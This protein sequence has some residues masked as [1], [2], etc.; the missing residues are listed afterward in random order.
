MKT[1]CLWVMSAISNPIALCGYKRGPTGY[2]KKHERALR[3]LDKR[4]RECVRCGAT[5][6]GCG[7]PRIVLRD[8]GR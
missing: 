1:G 7:L 3:D 5:D 4:P 2:C 6:C 8:R